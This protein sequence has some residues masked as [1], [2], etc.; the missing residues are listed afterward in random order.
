MFERIKLLTL[1]QLGGRKKKVVHN[2]K[3]LL[4]SVLLKLLTI[5]AITLVMYFAFNFIKN[6]FSFPINKSVLTFVLFISQYISII[7]STSALMSI[8]YN[9]KDNAILL[10]YPAKH[11]EV[12][13][14]KLV[15]SYL[16][17]LNKN[18]FVLLPLFISF[19]VLNQ[20][21]FFYY[22]ASFI[23]F[24][25]LPIFPVFIGAIL[26]IPL[27][28]IKK[29]FKKF[30]V[31]Y[32]ILIIGLIVG[33]FFLISAF[34]DAIPKPLRLVAIYNKFINGFLEF[35]SSANKFALFY[36]F[37]TDIM[38]SINIW[39]NSLWL[40]LVLSGI[41]LLTNY[42]SMPLY[43]NL[44]SK[45]NEHQNSN[46]VKKLKPVNQ[47]T[48]FTAFLTKE[49]KLTFRNI[50]KVINDYALIIL[51]P[52]ILFI[53]NVALSA[54]I[55]T[56][57]GRAIIAGFNIIV[58]MVLVSAC[59]TQSAT[60]ITTEGGEFVLLK[61]APSKTSN[62]VWAKILI[63]FIV[64]TFFI[65]LSSLL[66]TISNAVTIQNIWPICA[67]MILVNWSHILMS[68]QFDLLNPKLRDYAESG[69][70]DNNPNANKSVLVGLLIGI[71]IGALAI[72]LLNEDMILGWYKIV[73]IALAF[74]ILRL[75]LFVKNL[76]V[77]FK[78]IEY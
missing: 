39:L 7:T 58:G 41:V 11:N 2:K 46:K 63:N 32:V 69:K 5:V 6:Y 53:M 16:E 52:I 36:N 37:V 45:S 73:T 49:L 1:L 78:R 22:I 38:Y 66:M 68:F 26:S 31:L 60:A 42:I 28:Y 24:L 29:L 35:V 17:Q 15:V 4:V 33:V 55:V 71:I 40:I 19:G 59:N 75:Y 61:T 57:L 30:P 51:M 62:M 27:A 56:D 23:M 3:Q 9:S 74:F 12:F 43:F 44:A 13:I 72:F 64:S 47:K 18:L 34:I 76:R 67:I 50:N 48:T 8:L 65:L 14:S 20:V 10:S 54:I 21:A 70:T 25:V 77:F